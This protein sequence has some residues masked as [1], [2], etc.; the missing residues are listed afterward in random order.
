MSESISVV[1]VEDD[2]DIRELVD[3]IFGRT[4]GQRAITLEPSADVLERIRLARPDIVL[5]DVMMPGIDGRTLAGRIKADP[6]LSGVPFVFITAEA[7][8][9]E[10]EELHKLGALWV[11]SKPFDPLKL[12]EEIRKLLAKHRGR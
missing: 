4:P 5:L 6:E 7:R 2:P 8:P 1:Y 11:I 9:H 3:I 10:L 12:P